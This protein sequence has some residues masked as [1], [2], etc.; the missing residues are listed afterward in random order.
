LGLCFLHEPLAFAENG[1]TT[2]I[3]IN[4]KWCGHERSENT[5]CVYFYCGREGEALSNFT[6]SKATYVA[7]L[8]ETTE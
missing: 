3:K 8:L 4:A 1:V 2:A 7:R 5:V 6:L